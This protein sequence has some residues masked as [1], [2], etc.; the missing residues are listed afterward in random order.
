METYVILRRGGWPTAVDLGE[1]AARSTAEG[2]RMEDDI[3]WIR[4]YVLS[5][6]DG[7]VGTV[8]IYEASSPRRSAATL[9]GRPSGRRDHRRRR[10]RR[11]T[12][13]P[14]NRREMRKEG[15]TMRKSLVTAAICA[16]TVASVGASAAFAGEITGNG[17]PTGAPAHANSFCAF[18]GQNDMNPDEGQ[19]D[20]RT[21]TPKMVLPELLVTGSPGRPSR[22]AAGAEATRITRRADNHGRPRL[23]SWAGADH[24][25]RQPLRRHELRS[26][27][28]DPARRAPLRTGPARRIDRTRARPSARRPGRR[29]CRARASS[30]RR[31]SPPCLRT[32]CSRTSNAGLTR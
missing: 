21:Q 16:A 9:G 8:C 14:G 10:H 6:T 4:S 29:P 30:R 11:R 2:E 26:S 22:T 5:E 24:F 19:V 31:R 15:M 25:G 23:P 1:A 12:A 32:G 7:S 28:P 18:S 17:K 13:R 27:T 3:R 20:R